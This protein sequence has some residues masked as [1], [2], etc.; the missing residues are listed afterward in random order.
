MV[1]ERA[2]I[3]PRQEIAPNF[4]TI[5]RFSWEEKLVAPLIART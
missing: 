2:E 5:I 4:A 3:A 1:P